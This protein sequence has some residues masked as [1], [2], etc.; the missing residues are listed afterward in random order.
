MIGLQDVVA[1]VT[2]AA[3]GIGRAVVTAMKEAGAVVIATDRADEPGELGGDH[4]LR[5]DVVN[6]D[7]WQLVEALARERYGRLD[8]LVNVAAIS[9]VG[10]IEDTPL[11]QW[12]RVNAINE[13]GRAHV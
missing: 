4:Y 3:G 5:H 12:H 13:I 1:V 2:G 8:A 11:A 7:D 6:L 10:K 9:I